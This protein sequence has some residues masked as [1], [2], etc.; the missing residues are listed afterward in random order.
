MSRETLPPARVWY[1]CPKPDRRS[2]RIP[3]PPCATCGETRVVVASRTECVVY[4]RC[5]DCCYV[6]SVAKPLRDLSVTSQHAPLQ[7]RVQANVD[8]AG[9]DK[10]ESSQ[11]C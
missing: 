7:G 3:V 10:G 4:L 2:H 11:S 1:V 5:P 9:I 6:W 8:G